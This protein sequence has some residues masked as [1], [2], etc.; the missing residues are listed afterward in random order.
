M[1]WSQRY[2]RPPKTG[3]ERPFRRQLIVN[4]VASGLSNGWAM[5][6]GLVSVPLLLAG[7]GRE[8]FG[9]WALVMTFSA[10]NGWLSLADLG[11][12]VATTRSVAAA[13]SLDDHDAAR[14]SVGAGAVVA[15]TASAI[16]SLL[17]V[18]S[19]AT[20][21]PE[22]FRL[23]AEL[24]SPFR[25]ALALMAVQ[26]IVDQVVNVAEAALEGLQRVD[27]SRAVD[28]VRR[29]LVLGGAAGA[30]LATGDLRWTVAGS[31]AGSV[32]SAVGAVVLLR[33]RLPGGAAIPT[34]DD[35][36]A[37]VRTGR[38]VAVLRPLGVLQRTMDRV[39]VGVV[40]GPG[41]VA[42]VE[43]ATQLQA[44]AEAVLSATS[45]SVVPASSWLAARGDR[46][47]LAEL[48]RRGTRFAVLATV[49][50]A[51]GIALL[52]G[53][54]VHLWVGGGYAEVAGLTAVA[55]LCVVVNA[56]LAVGSQA[57]V[58]IGQTQVVLRSAAVAMAVNLA[59]SWVLL[60]T[61]GLVG[62]FL[63]TLLANVVLL[64][65]LGP[66]VLAL[67]RPTASAS[68]GASDGERPA[69]GGVLRP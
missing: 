14:R 39:L 66:P 22:L 57:L 23:P 68:G 25:T 29:L 27:L 59:A 55:V 35:V 11:S 58:G 62:A 13:A 53:P 28:M 41:A 33:R 20:F 1:S 32:T 15:L 26:V 8:A 44:G 61:V 31:L 49:P 40:M 9:A 63:G 64:V 18:A 7:L 51:G 10:T 17:L 54:F 38:D 60:E 21:L 3:P 36:R 30:A 56:P 50:V 4:T 5:V 34:A 52:A 37:T 45:Y 42:V 69:V 43:L 2:R 16:A 67:T 47:S 19:A 6:A 12:V 24:V 48:V 46:G 65:V